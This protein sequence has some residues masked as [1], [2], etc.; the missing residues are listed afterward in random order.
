MFDPHVHAECLTW[1]NLKEMKMCGIDRI[2]SYSY[3]PHIAKSLKANAFFDFFDRLLTQERWRASQF[4][5]QL[6]VAVGVLS[7]CTPPDVH[8]VLARLPEYLALEDC[9]AIGEVGIDPRSP[10]LRSM[11]KQE[12]LLK[13]QLKVARDLNKPISIHTPP[14]IETVREMPKGSIIYD[15]EEI[16]K[17][18]I[19]IV[20]EIGI[21]PDLVVIDHLENKRQVEMVLEAG[22]YAELTVQPWRGVFPD[23]VADILEDIVP[24]LGSNR[25]MVSSDTSYTPSDHLGVPKTVFELGKLGI[26]SDVV[27][28]IFTKNPSQFYKL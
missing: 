25:I 22:F 26:G 17:R 13:E 11:E 5:I 12:E 21:S 24:K 9:V 4:M 18:D 28:Q 16:I 7:V 3:Y 20:K 27:E 14:T 15:K 23:Q 10:T 2:V 6:Y 19:E 8:L 1:E